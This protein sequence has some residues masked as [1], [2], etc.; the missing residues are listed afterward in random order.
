MMSLASNLVIAASRQGMYLPNIDLAFH[1]PY[2]ADLFFGL[3]RLVEKL[4]SAVSL[5]YVHVQIPF[6]LMICL[7]TY[8]EKPLIWT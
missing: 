2:S 6:L 4:S 1:V 5:T 7:Q 8:R 3:A